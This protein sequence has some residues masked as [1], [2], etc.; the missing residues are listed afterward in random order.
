[1][2]DQQIIEME[3]LKDALVN[4]GKEGKKEILAN[5]GKGVFAQ[6]EMKSKEVLVNIGNNI[7]LKKTPEETKKIIEQQVVQLM[8]FKQQFMLQLE[9]TQ[10]QLRDLVMSA[11]AEQAHECDGS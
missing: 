3:A 5:I 6:A 1:M 7:V 9:A 4:L 8:D 10:S 11:R 2:V